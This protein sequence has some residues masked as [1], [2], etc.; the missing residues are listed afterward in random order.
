VDG[1]A[2]NIFARF[3]IKQAR[4]KLCDLFCLWH[5]ECEAV[6]PPIKNRF[7]LPKKNKYSKKLSSLNH[8]SFTVRRDMV[9]TI[10]KNLSPS[11]RAINFR[12]KTF[13]KAKKLSFKT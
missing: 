1:T 8:N 3:S 5:I 4:V 7:A 12:K 10:Q 6:T 9:Y 13:E 11:K 2:Y